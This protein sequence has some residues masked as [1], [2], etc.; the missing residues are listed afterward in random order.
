MARIRSIKPE[1]RRSLT[2]GGWPREVRLAFIYLW[3]YLD[4]DGRGHDDLRL[5]RSE[6]FPLDDDVTIR[7][8]DKWLHQMATDK[9][10][11]NHWPP[12]CRY[13]VAGRRYL[14]AVYWAEHQR[15][16]RPTSSA[17]PPCPVH[18]E[19]MSA[20]EPL[21]EPSPPSRA[22]AEQGAGS[23]EQGREQGAGSREQGSADAHDNGNGAVN[24]ATEQTTRVLLDLTG[25][26]TPVVRDQL[27]GQIRPMLDAGIRS[28]AIAA[29][30][31]DWRTRERP[32]PG[33]LPLLV[34]D[35]LTADER[36]DPR[37]A[38]LLA[39]ARRSDQ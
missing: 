28:D 39:D 35:Q 22:R 26:W 32:R 11:E 34:Q 33:L 20:H 15:I 6:L 16:N 30:L 1:I 19:D 17:L 36:V 10:P 3:M 24:H 21:T 38:G 7:K 13:E 29:G 23:K 4:D 12:L 2:V 37:F 31:T 8:L 25:P 9:N 5:I 14:H 18:D 27:A